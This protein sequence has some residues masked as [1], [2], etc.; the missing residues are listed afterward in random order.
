MVFFFNQFII[1]STSLIDEFLFKVHFYCQYHILS[2]K[3]IYLK[4][5]S[6]LSYRKIKFRKIIYTYETIIY[7]QG[8][9]CDGG[10]MLFFKKEYSDS[11][12]YEN[13]LLWSSR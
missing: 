2:Q 12:F 4:T 7:L 11:H 8:K 9:E 3:F 13:K 10:S 6:T 5:L 1:I